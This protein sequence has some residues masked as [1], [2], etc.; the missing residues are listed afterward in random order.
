MISTLTTVVSDAIDKHPATHGQPVST[1]VLSKIW[2]GMAGYDRQSLKP[3]INSAISKLFRVSSEEGLR[4]S[5]DIDLLPAALASNADITSV[6]V[7]VVG[8][9]SVA[10]NYRRGGQDFRRTGR[11]GGWGR[12]LGDDGSGY[13]IGREGIRTTLRHCDLHNLKKSAGADPAPF[14]PL[15]QAILEHFQQKAPDC[16]PETLLDHLLFPDS[17]GLSAESNDTARTKSIASAASV[18][19]SMASRN[20]EAQLIMQA[21]ASSVAQLVRMLVEGQNVDVDHCALILGGGLMGNSV[22][23]ETVCD[24]LRE[25]CGEFG[26]VRVIDQPVISGAEYLLRSAMDTT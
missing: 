4:I 12:L 8:T 11:V 19:L 22:Y 15:P 16:T 21:G 5:S 3:L 20:Q 1:I 10:M 6:I 25:E 2:V 23:K 18:V 26:Q 24:I 17:T 13:A 9:G 7:L 14:E